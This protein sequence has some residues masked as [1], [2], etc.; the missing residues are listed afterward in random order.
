MAK[1]VLLLEFGPDNDK[2][3]EVRPKHREYL[4]SLLDAGKLH[5]SDPWLDDSGALIVYEV[6]D[7]AEARQ[8]IANDPYTAAGVVARS[9]LKGWNRIMAAEGTSAT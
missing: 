2:R 9:T 4:K 8:I 3:L 7:E 1:F 5:E 6:A